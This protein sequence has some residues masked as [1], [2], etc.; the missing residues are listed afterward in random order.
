M[1]TAPA[2]ATS[3]TNITYTLV[4]TN[5]A[6]TTPHSGTARDWLPPVHVTFVS[7]SAGCTNT[8]GTVTCTS[9]TLAPSATQPFT[10]TVHISV[11]T[12][13]V[14]INTANVTATN[15]TEDTNP[16]NNAPTATTAGSPQTPTGKV[17]G[18]G[19]T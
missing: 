19:L 7:A 12:T 11:A 2:T 9:G 14:L 13:G 8:A 3:G 15:P 4:V 10:I 6:S 17:T 16:A 18:D 5:I 1:K